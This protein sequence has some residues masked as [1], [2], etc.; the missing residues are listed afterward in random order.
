MLGVNGNKRQEDARHICGH[1]SSHQNQ[2]WPVVSGAAERALGPKALTL[3]NSSRTQPLK[4][5]ERNHF[6]VITRINFVSRGKNKT[7]PFFFFFFFFRVESPAYVCS[8]ARGRIR[9]A[10]ASL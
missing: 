10:A 2:P 5:P 9:A 8:Q 4:F 1:K 3:V 6:N 7:F